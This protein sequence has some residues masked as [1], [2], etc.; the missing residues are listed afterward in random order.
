MRMRN[1]HLFGL[2][3]LLLSV[4]LLGSHYSSAEEI[5]IITGT[6]TSSN[7]LPNM[8][9]FST[10]GDT[11]TGAGQGCAVGAYCTSGESG[12]G[13]TYS[14][15]FDLPMTQDQINSGFDLNYG[16]DVKSHST[17]VTAPVCNGGNVDCKDTWTLTVNLLQDTN[18]VQTFTHTVV[19][20]FSGS[21]SYAY[22][23]TIVA[24]S[25][26]NLTGK[27]SLF[28][29]DSGFQSGYHGPQFSSPSLTATYNLISYIEQ[30][31]LN[32]IEASEIL[33]DVVIEPEM[34]VQVQ[35]Q[36]PVGEVD[37]IEVA[38]VVAEIEIVETEVTVAAEIEVEQ[39]IEVQ[40]AEVVEEEVESSQETKQEVKQKI[41]KKILSKMGSKG[42]YD[43]TN[44]LKTLI[45]M[46][47]LGGTKEFFSAQTQL[48]DIQGFFSNGI[49]P[50][51]IIKDNNFA[52]FM[53]KGK[54]H[55]AMNALIDSQYK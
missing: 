49:V 53:L 34:I 3:L 38:P 23:Q 6:E 5:Q 35:I 9:T 54:S 13:G 46:Q 19:L 31:V 39:E 32:I 42:R 21:R 52:S 18:I 48:P 29:I 43:N 1:K 10:S 47:V 40:V 2:H 28:G 11:K 41:A 26:E 8:S 4:F 36:S 17:N 15:T 25:Y 14:S 20:D 12:G 30:E 22:E 51:S 33:E 45:V 27:F 55:I 37:I 16:V 24:N 7:L 44:Q 50:D